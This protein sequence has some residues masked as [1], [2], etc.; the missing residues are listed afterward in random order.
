MKKLKKLKL[1]AIILITFC[2][3]S[4]IKDGDFTIPDL[5]N[6][7]EYTNVKSLGEI[8]DLYKGKLVAF[9]EE[10]TTYGY[11]VSNDREGNFYKS[12][13]IQ[14]SPENPTIGF[15]IKINDTKLNARYAVGRK[16]IIKLKGLF[17]NKNTEGSYQLGTKNIYGNGINEI[18][19]ND[20]VRYI[21][22]A[23]EIATIIPVVINSNQLTEKNLNTLVKINN[24]QSE[25]KGLKYASPKPG[26]S[27]YTVNRTMVSCLNLEKINIVN[28]VFATYSALLI[29]DKKG[30]VTGVFNIIENQKQITIRDINDI[31]F[32]QEYG[33]NNNPTLASISEIIELYSN[34]ETP[35]S[36]NLKIKIVITSDIT[37]RNISNQKAFAQDTSAGI[38]LNFTDTYNL[39]LGDEIEIAVGGLLLTKTNGKLALNL[40]TKNILTTTPGT[41]PM[42]EQITIAQA[43]T[44]NYENKLVK[45]ESVQF[46]NTTKKYVGANTLT[47]DCDNE[48]RVLP[49]TTNAT[50]SNNNVSN[51]KGTITGIITQNNGTYLH[52]RAEYD[53]NFINDYECTPVNTNPISNDL[54]FSE[55]AEGTSNN[56]YIEIYNGTN[57]EVDLSIY[58]VELYINGGTDI[59]RS[60]DLSTLTN[61]K[62]KKE[63]VLV[64]Y[65]VKAIDLI[66]NE[67]DITSGV[68]SFNGDDTVILKKNNTII[69]V[70]GQIGEDPGK[71]WQ[72]A[73]I[74]NATQ[75]HTLIRKTTV[76]K[77]NVDWTTSSG[78]NTTNSEWEVKN[79]DDF[80][81]V[82]KNNTFIK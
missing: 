77:G 16:I 2:L 82:G 54:F 47:S 3:Y 76:T 81:S 64:I 42:P 68:T 17:L 51:K 66:K 22:R 53:I 48:L 40:S 52:I 24:L 73:G 38:A 1:T 69:D 63:E 30:S 31:N 36:Q 79:E 39:N 41:L 46:K 50:F 78:T 5:N 14:D 43:L 59:Y 8:A 61:T 6:N 15:E 60:I 9:D 26:N 72:V 56:K 44:G 19:V 71:G 55:Y 32:T 37:N 67:G 80:T 20:Y 62:L 58:K 65:N 35:I 7:E 25:T 57:N 27:I 12:L 33:C 10:I 34:E 75:N 11:V 21:D 49:V 13:F 18:S 70:I 28:S 45:I 29:P 23:S 74:E 4:C